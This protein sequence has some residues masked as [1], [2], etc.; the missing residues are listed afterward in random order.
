MSAAGIFTAAGRDGARALL[1]A[2]A[3][4]G[5]ATL[6]A[7]PARA[8]GAPADS[9]MHEWFRSMTDSTDAYFGLSAQPADTAGLDSVLDWALAQPPGALQ[10][11]GSR[12]SLAPLFAF[13]RAVGAAYGG[14]ASIGIAPGL[15]RLGGSLQWANGPNEWYGDGEYTLERGGADDDEGGWTF[16]AGAGRRFEPL[17]RDYYNYT[18]ATMGALFYGSDRHSYVRRD[19]MRTELRVRGADRWVAA[20]YRNELESPLATTATWTL[21]NDSPAVVPNVPAAFG[22]A[23]EVRLSA[24]AR[25][26]GVPFSAEAAM[27]NAGGALG[28]DLAYH[29]YR[30][31]VGGGIALGR[32]LALAPQFEYTRLTGSALP[33]DV[34]YLG[35]VYSLHT[36]DSQSLAGTGRTVARAELL[37]L[38]DVLTLLRL[39][40]DTAFPIQLAAFGTTAARWGYDPA[41]GA[42]RVTARDWPGREQW[43]SEA[44]VSVLYRPGLPDPDSYFRVDYAW[45]VGPDDREAKLYVSWKRTLHLLRRR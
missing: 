9:A 41:T 37:L 40:R 17:N 28:G 3:L 30:G 22:R 11:R 12:L 20:A 15:G 1:A 44:G 25:V 6:A 42:P 7:A 26:P 33:Q 18:F 38:D 27:W 32:H 23:S 5:A 2:L 14:S 10:R 39:R 19:G 29:R 35:G 21:T 13:N 31:A 16:R 34:P 36:V 24:G 8:Q 45:P 43:M 4:A